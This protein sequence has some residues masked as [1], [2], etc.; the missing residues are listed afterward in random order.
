V[1]RLVVIIGAASPIGFTA[2][3]FTSLASLDADVS[4]RAISASLL[5]GVIGVPLAVALT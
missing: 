5:I 3:T 4:A 2:L 1:T